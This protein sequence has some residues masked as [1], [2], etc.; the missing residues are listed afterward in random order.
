[1][2]RQLQNYQW[3]KAWFGIVQWMWA[4]WTLLQEPVTYNIRCTAW[5]LMEKNRMH[6]SAYFWWS[7]S[8]IDTIKRTWDTF[9]VIH[10]FVPKDGD[11]YHES[12]TIF[13]LTVSHYHFYTKSS[14]P[15]LVMQ[16]KSR[17]RSTEIVVTNKWR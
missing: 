17:K 2:T 5:S 10:L 15:T 13:P 12:T 1:M 7:L 4:L 8:C 16:L 11:T 14:I 3:V 9:V 6:W